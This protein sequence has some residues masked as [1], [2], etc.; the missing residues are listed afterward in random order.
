MHE[1]M[2]KKKKKNNPILYNLYAI[3]LV[4][5]SWTL[6]HICY[7]VEGIEEGYYSVTCGF[8]N[9]RFSTFEELIERQN[10]LS[11]S[12]P[13][14]VFTIADDPF[15]KKWKLIGNR[16]VEYK[17]VNVEEHITGTWGWY[18]KEEK[19]TH[20]VLEMYF[21]IYP[22]D[23]FY[24]KIFMDNLLIPGQKKPPFARDKSSFSE[25]ELKSIGL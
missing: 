4:D 22:W 3:P 23:S 8:F 6:G 19:D 17:N 21:G 7:L 10:E 18:D 15:K 13:V 9:H 25:I 16:K 1:K 12:K 24:D 20:W 11:L 14:F 5:G 2:I